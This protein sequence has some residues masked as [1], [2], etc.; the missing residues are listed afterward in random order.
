MLTE[1]AKNLVLQTHDIRVV[2]V[3]TIDVIGSLSVN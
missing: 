3:K 2:S 1:E